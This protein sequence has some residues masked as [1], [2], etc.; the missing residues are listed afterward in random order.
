MTERRPLA[1]RCRALATH[2]RFE[3]FILACIGANCV[4]LALDRPTAAR[5]P[6]WLIHADSVLSFIFL[7]E[8]TLKLTGFGRAYWRGGALNWLDAVVA[9][10]GGFSAVVLYAASSG[11]VPFNISVLR[12]A[13]LVRPLRTLNRFPSVRTVVDAFVSSMVGLASIL[14]ILGGALGLFGLL[15]VTLWSGL[16][17]GRCAVGAD[18]AAYEA[19]GADDGALLLADGAR[20][21]CRALRGGGGGGGGGGASDGAPSLS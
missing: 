17:H 6:L 14:A 2:P 7:G 15:C 10:E 3:N 9:C 5:P 16:D 12:M 20:L 1:A 8:F 11:G 18:A 13:R 21:A 19:E 4:L